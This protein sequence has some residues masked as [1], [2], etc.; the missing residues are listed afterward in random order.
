MW[1]REI[2]GRGRDEEEEEEERGWRR[3]ERLN[4]GLAQAGHK[5]LLD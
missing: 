1:M 2:E 4:K 3:G 5:A